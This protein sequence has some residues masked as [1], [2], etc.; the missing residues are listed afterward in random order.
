MRL[1]PFETRVGAARQLRFLQPVQAFEVPQG[2]VAGLL[3]TELDQTVSRGEFRKEE[4]LL[5]AL[6]LLSGPRSLRERMLGFQSSSLSGFYSPASDRLYLVAKAG[7]RISRADGSVLVHELTHALQA[8][9]TQLLTATLGISEDQDLLFALGTL[10]EGDALWTEQ[11]DMQLQLGLAPPCPEAFARQFAADER[12]LGDEEESRWI[13]E[14]LLEQYPRGYALAVSLVEAGGTAAL[15][16]A[17][18]DP[19]LSSEE[20]LHPERYLRPGR[21]HVLRDLRTPLALFAPHRSCRLEAQDSFGEIG[22]RIWARERGLAAAAAAAA[23][24]GW[25]ADRA[26]VLTCPR[27]ETVAWLIQF[28]SPLEARALE[29][30]LVGHGSAGLRL[31]LRGR[32]LLLSRG[33]GEAGRRYLL[34]QLKGRPVRNLAAWLRAHPEVDRRAQLVRSRSRSR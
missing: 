21:R 3:E 24:A 19:P 10:L 34:E 30:A 9:H 22:L 27:G 20:V 18:R 11:R 7:A 26:W 29:S 31:S 32:R 25:D 8:Q 16:A 14:S 23:A 28:D 33:L 1:Q 17:L 6:G 4:A 13:W 15:D 5:R 12:A 2:R